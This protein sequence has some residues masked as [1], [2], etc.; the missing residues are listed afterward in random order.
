VIGK[1][2][3]LGCATAP[4]VERMKSPLRAGSPLAFVQISRSFAAAFTCVNS[5]NLNFGLAETPH[6]FALPWICE[7]TQI[8]IVPSDAS[9]AKMSL[10]ERVAPYKELA[11]VT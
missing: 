6:I 8:W 9:V 2:S 4:V 3:H 5:G 7:G 10:G 1:K 11:N